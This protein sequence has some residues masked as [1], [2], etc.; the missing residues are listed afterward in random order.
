MVLFRP[1]DS[2]LRTCQSSS[3]VPLARAN[4]SCMASD[5]VHWHSGRMSEVDA[6]TYVVRVTR[7]EQAAPGQRAQ[8]YAVMAETAGEASEAVRKA[9]APSAYVEVTDGKLLPE[10]ARLLGLKPGVAKAM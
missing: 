4:F 3:E 10:T 8:F 1:G 2:R 7:H 9:V 5:S 6:R